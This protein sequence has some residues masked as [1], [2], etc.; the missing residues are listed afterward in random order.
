MKR[1][2]VL[3]LSVLVLACSRESTTTASAGAAVTQAAIRVRG[4]PAKRAR[5]EAGAAL[6]GRLDPYE[7]AT[8]AVRL[9][10]ILSDVRVD[11]GD[12]VR[13]GQVLAVLSVPGLSSQAEAALAA[14]EAA[15]H[16]ME[17]RD[18]AAQRASTVAER[19]RAAISEQEVR[20]AKSAVASA[21]ARSASAGAEARRLRDLVNDTR[22]VAPFDGV[23]VTRRKDRGASV[24][25][26]DVVLE[27]ARVDRLRIRLEVPEAE[28]GFVS[29]G[30]P[31]SITLASIGGR[32]LDAA[33][34]R[35]APA[36]DPKT[37]MLPVEVDVPND[38]TLIAGVLAE[39]R[40]KN[41]ARSGVIVIP[42]EALVHEGSAA[43][44]YVAGS[45]VAHRRVVRPGYDNGVQVEIQEGVSEGDV[46]LIGGRG[47]LRDG[48]HVE[49]AR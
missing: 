47:L 29:K 22:L 25:A 16:E 46:V 2:L 42:S 28:A 24:S 36:L 48:V 12:R 15:Q 13:A 4:V 40:L 35:F 37:R 44:V 38:G 23:I 8:L 39:V 3:S 30:A 45:D 6:I 18:D 10:G 19:N 41:Q 21:Q 14:S 7:R 17:V 27:V 49:V 34:S 1:V 20:A 26:G 5:V 9:A 43:V 11:V 33:I 31:V 32:S